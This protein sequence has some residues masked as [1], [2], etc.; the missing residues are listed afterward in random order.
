MA[1]INILAHVLHTCMF[2]L[3]MSPS[4]SQVSQ[5]SNDAHAKLE[6][7]LEKGQYEISYYNT[8][9]YFALAG[10]ANLAF[11]YLTKAIDEGFSSPDVMQEDTDLLTL[12]NDSRWA[13]VQKIVHDNQL[14][15]QK[16]GDLFF[17]KK[18]FWEAGAI[19]TPYAQNISEDEKIAG[20][21]KFWSEAKY[22]FVNF[23]LIPRLN[24][25]SLYLAYLSKVRLTKSTLDYYRVLEQFAA[26]L[27]DGHTNVNMPRELVDSVYARPLVRTRLIEG[28]VLI[29]GV[30]DPA[31]R[32]KGIAVGQEVIKVDRLPVKEYATRFV[33]PYQSASTTQ[34][35]LVRAYDYALLRGSLTQPIKLQLQDAAGKI[36]EHT[37]YRVKPEERSKKLRTPSFQF[38]MLPGDI[39]YVALNSFGNDSTAIEFK[40]RFSEISKA[41]A[42]IFDVRN[43]GGGNT[44]PGWNILSCLTDTSTPVHASYTREYR[45]TYRAWSRSQDV[46]VSKDNLFPNQKLLYTKPVVVLTS[47]R[48][49]SAA[50]DFVAAFKSMNRGLILGEST[51]GSSGQPLVISLPGNGSARMCTKRDLLG[52]GSDFVGLG[53]QPDK[54]VVP[55][56]QDIRKGVDTEL[57][58]AIQEVMKMK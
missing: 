54:V 35:Q 10:K 50:E 4:Y 7:G 1:K 58:A 52:D 16:M 21:S 40:S 24:F 2:V 25:D 6:A 49:F 51:G 36:S 5:G 42:I 44:G 19:E 20:L 57:Q 18:S 38:K 14:Q 27:R 9:C 31:L 22:N 8:A 23:D 12:H 37:L 26:S 55:T 43:N 30:Y 29:I 13:I 47:A 48:T 17:N 45:P 41:R 53:I 46:Y 11:L 32:E 34:D 56:V 39:A 28:K 15:K 3:V 33:M